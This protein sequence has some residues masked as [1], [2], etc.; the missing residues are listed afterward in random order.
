MF[1]DCHNCTRGIPSS[2]FD[3]EPT[4]FRDWIKSIEK[5]VLWGEMTTN[6]KGLL[7]RPAG[8]LLVITF[9]GM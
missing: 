8:V 2:S 4:K 9:K 1:I 5:Y 6:Q 7:T 3:G